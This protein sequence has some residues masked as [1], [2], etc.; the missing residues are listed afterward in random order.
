MKE[1]LRSFGVNSPSDLP[2]D[3]EAR[4]P[5]AGLAAKVSG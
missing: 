1:E 3:Q 5:L 2:Q 4:S